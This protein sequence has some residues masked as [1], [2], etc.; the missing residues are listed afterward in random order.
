M[1]RGGFRF[2]WHMDVPVV[3]IDNAD[4]Q[5]WSCACLET[6]NGICRYPLPEWAPFSWF[7]R[8]GG[9]QCSVHEVPNQIP[10][11][12]ADEKVDHGNGSASHFGRR[13]PVTHAAR[14]HCVNEA[15][16]PTLF[17]DHFNQC[18]CL[19]TLHLLRGR[20]A[21]FLAAIDCRRQEH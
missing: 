18:K 15:F 21:Q 2:E 20:N 14:S 6:Q 9:S 19:R 3:L 8:Y 7:D 10:V 13:F 4:L 16:L 12:N 1:R 11:C 17:Q 5:E